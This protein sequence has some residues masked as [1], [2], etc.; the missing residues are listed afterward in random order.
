MGAAVSDPICKQ[1]ND[2]HRMELNESEVGCTACPSPCQRCRTG[3]NGAYCTVT[4]CACTCHRNGLTDLDRLAQL[5]DEMET[6]YES[7]NRQVLDAEQRIKIANA[8]TGVTAE[9]PL[10]DN[11]KLCWGK[12]SEQW[13]LYVVYGS[14]PGRQPLANAPRDVRA[15][16]LVVMPM[17]HGA[18]VQSALKMRDHLGAIGK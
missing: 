15:A 11:I 5:G 8:K 13:R 17:L 10:V 14:D 7:L 1:C 2:T 4:P 16:A 12:V 6:L 3:G 18:L 9:V